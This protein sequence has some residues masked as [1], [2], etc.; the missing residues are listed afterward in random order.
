[1]GVSGDR[2]VF[3]LASVSINNALQYEQGRRGPDCPHANLELR[4][5]FSSSFCSSIRIDLETAIYRLGFYS[6]PFFYRAF[7]PLPVQEVPHR[8]RR[9]GKEKY[10]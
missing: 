8:E 2:T 10:L 5:C 4:N 6:W 7:G 9:N 3:R 1:M